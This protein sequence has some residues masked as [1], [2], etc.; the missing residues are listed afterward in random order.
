MKSSRGAG[1]GE[2]EKGTHGTR[3]LLV[4]RMKTWYNIKVR[5]AFPGM[6]GRGTHGTGD[7]RTAKRHDGV[8]CVILHRIG[9]EKAPIL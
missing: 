9:P 6:S 8:K 2:R 5:A 4:K 3:F 7:S 1:A